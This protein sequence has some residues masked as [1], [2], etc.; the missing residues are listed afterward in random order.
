MANELEILGSHGMQAYRYIEMIEMINAGKLSPESLI[1]ET[2]NLEESIT[3]F[4]S[5]NEFNT[6][7]VTVITEF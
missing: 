7:G 1:G 3:V 5:M 6:T 2:I 4:T